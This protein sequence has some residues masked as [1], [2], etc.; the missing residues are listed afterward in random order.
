MTAAASNAGRPRRDPNAA[1][2]KQ[3]DRR[4]LPV[5]Q[6]ALDASGAELVIFF[7]S[8]ARGDY[9]ALQSDIDIMLLQAPEPDAAGKEVIAAAALA[10]AQEG[11]GHAVPV[12]LLWRTPETFRYNRRYVNSI[13][14][15]ATRD[16][17]IMSRNPESYH[18]ADYEDEENEYEYDWG[19]YDA[20][21]ERAEDHLAAFRSL[22]ELGHSDTVIGQQAQNALEHGLK[23]LLEAHGAPYRNVHDI[24]ELL[25]NVHHR[26]PE[27]QEFH[28]A[29]Q[30]DIY[31][32]YAG[33]QGYQRVRRNPRLTNQ[34]DF[35]LKTVSDAE[36][37]IRRARAVRAQQ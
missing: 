6:A 29:I 21:I 10:A 24:G 37:I 7:G 20:R 15:N 33:R 2:A 9:D 5:A 12:Q 14:T 11:Y 16:G 17:I 34:E 26:D 4:A 31:T 22:A 30:P 28:L 18:P 27:M 25:G 23:A 3:Y 32:E 8:R 35:M 1:Q 19:E 13:E 36:F